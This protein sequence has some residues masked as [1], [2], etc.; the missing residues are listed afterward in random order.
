[1]VLSE[2]FGQLEPGVLVAGGNP[3][4]EIATRWV[5]EEPDPMITALQTLTLALCISVPADVACG[6]DV[7]SENP[8]DH[9]ITEHLPICT[10]Q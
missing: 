10:P 7:T 9:V 4:V 1:V 5:R 3:P 2:V 6:P 8:A